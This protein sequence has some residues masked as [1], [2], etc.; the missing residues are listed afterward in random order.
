VSRV[1]VGDVHR[2]GQE[3]CE[4]VLGESGE[5][6]GQGDATGGQGGRN[7]SKAGT[8]AAM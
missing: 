7:V 2:A 5:V 3:R 8:S 6:L 1:R 4:L